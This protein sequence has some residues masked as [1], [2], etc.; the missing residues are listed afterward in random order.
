MVSCKSGKEN[1]HLFTQLSEEETGID[2]QNHLDIKG[3]FNIYKYRNFYNGGGVG[4]GDIN[5]D[6]LMDLYLTSNMDKNRLF[7]NKGDFKFEDITANAGVGGERSWTTGVSMADV[8]GD[9]LL[10]IYVSNSGNIEGDDKRNELFINNG[11]LTFDEKAGD[12]GIADS[13]YSTHG[14]F[15]DYDKDGDL[16]LYL[17]N[18][19]FQALGSFNMDEN[20]RLERKLRE[21]MSVFFP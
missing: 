21:K 2:F 10:D 9:G 5:N 17:V 7:L 1:R 4:I 16:D 3:E 14:A 19:S 6:G 12:Y 8:N 13:G 15:F 11:N 18:N 20:R